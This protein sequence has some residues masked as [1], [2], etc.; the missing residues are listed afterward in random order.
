M[1]I[2]DGGDIAISESL[3]CLQWQVL[4]FFL[5]NYA[6]KWNYCIDFDTFKVK[7]YR[8]IIIVTI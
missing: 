3:Y 6:E 8:R 1:A 7:M 5:V 2:P 4:C